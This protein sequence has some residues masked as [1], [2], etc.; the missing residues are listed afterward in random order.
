MEGKSTAVGGSSG[1]PVMLIPQV[2]SPRE[3]RAPASPKR[4]GSQGSHGA[5]LLRSA[6]VA[7]PSCVSTVRTEVP[8][9][10]ATRAWLSPP[11]DAAAGAAAALYESD[12]TCVEGTCPLGGLELAIRRVGPAAHRR[13]L[14]RW[15]RPSPASARPSLATDHDEVRPHSF[16]RRPD[17][18]RVRRG[19]HGRW[20]RAHPHHRLGCPGIP[21]P[22][23]RV[24]SGRLLGVAPAREPITRP[25]HEIAGQCSYPSCLKNSDERLRMDGRA[26]GGR[27]PCGPLPPEGS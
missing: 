4:D 12:D 20:S 9:I 2:E 15:P 5:R 1:C 26:R 22:K 27:A 10:S 18:R 3:E 23:F 25:R 24:S 7:R 16:A 13:H 19:S 11:R 8:M 14:R 21:G 6:F 17:P